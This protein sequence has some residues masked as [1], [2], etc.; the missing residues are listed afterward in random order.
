[1][2]RLTFTLLAAMLA[3]FFGPGPQAGSVEP[4]PIKSAS[5]HLSR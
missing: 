2:K 5:V 3:A 4:Q 1:M